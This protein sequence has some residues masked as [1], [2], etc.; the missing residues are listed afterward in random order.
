MGAKTLKRL[1]MVPLEQVCVEGGF[2]GERVAVNREVTL[3]IAVPEDGAAGCVEAG[4]ETGR[5]ESA[6][7]VL[8]FG[9]G[10]VD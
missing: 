3:P 4:M 7:R 8:G 6:A 9:C 10:K 5:T 1:T 2:W